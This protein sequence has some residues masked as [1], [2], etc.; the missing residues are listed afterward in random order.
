MTLAEV[1]AETVEAALNFMYKGTVENVSA[2]MEA[3]KIFGLHP[4]IKVEERESTPWPNLKRYDT[5]K[6]SRLIDASSSKRS[7][8]RKRTKNKKFGDDYD[9]V[10][11]IEAFGP[12]SNDDNSAED[13]AG[14]AFTF[15]LNEDEYSCCETDFHTRADLESHQKSFGCI[16]RYTVV[17]IEPLP[18]QP[19]PADDAAGE[20]CDEGG[21]MSKPSPS[22]KVRRIA[23]QT[24]NRRK[25]N[26]ESLKCCDTEFDNE[27]IYT[28][29][30]EVG[31]EEKPEGD[32]FMICCNEK[33]FG[34]LKVHMQSS[35]KLDDAT[36]QS[37]CCDHTFE[38]INDLTKHCAS[39]H[40]LRLSQY[41]RMICCAT[42]LSNFEEWVQHKEQTEHIECNYCAFLSKDERH[43]SLHLFS[44][45]KIGKPEKDALKC[46]HCEKDDFK[47][48]SER[49]EH[50]DRHDDSVKY[51]CLSCNKGF[52]LMSSLKTHMYRLG[53]THNPEAK[54]YTCD[55]CK[56]V[57]KTIIG[58]RKHYRVEHQKKD[59]SDCTYCDLTFLDKGRLDQHTKV[60]H[61]KVKDVQCTSCGKL[62]ATHERM[63][64]HE[65]FVH[66]VEDAKVPCD[67]C[68]KEFS[69]K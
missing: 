51:S 53:K 45:H 14:E 10:P 11:T 6:K 56:K 35:H 41:K 9:D 31:H 67:I 4:K 27:L 61:M 63:K 24:Q 32:K 68:L 49:Q 23:R 26:R 21:E 17:K 36:E 34:T 2:L 44:K 43:L 20:E 13:N 3:S 5:K 22:K 37:K 59:T 47:N 52:K 12:G 55:V 28:S 66:I 58:R 69:N 30:K 15:S 19:I 39:T 65:K 18:S 33:I 62:F 29:H 16:Q 50:E 40:G 46:K 64:I 25:M 7:S 54:E 60:V 42:T 57:F 48:I 8:G 38:G 1:K